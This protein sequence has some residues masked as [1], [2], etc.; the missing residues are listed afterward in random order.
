MV[1]MRGS[2]AVSA[3]GRRIAGA[4]VSRK[5]EMIQS[6]HVLAMGSGVDVRRSRRVPRRRAQSRLRVEPPPRHLSRRRPD[7]VRP[8]RRRA[9]RRRRP[10]PGAP[11]TWQKIEKLPTR[12]RPSYGFV[13]F[14]QDK[15]TFSYK[16]PEAEFKRYND[17]YGYRAEDVAALQEWRDTATQS[18][19]RLAVASHKSQAQVDAAAAA[20]QK[21]YEQKLARLPRNR[22]A[23]CWR[24]AA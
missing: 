18:S 22:A 6:R 13:D 2:G 14:K 3:I 15:I 20:V 8:G 1:P 11:R 4:G 5:C 10:A 16:I 9:S 24:R 23:S 17:A 19:Y 7:R 21:E 12:A